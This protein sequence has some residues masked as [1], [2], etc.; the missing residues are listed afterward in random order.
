[1]QPEH[2]QRLLAELARV[3]DL[4]LLA[5]EP[6]HGS[7]DA[8][9]SRFRANFSWTHPYRRYGEA[10]GLVTRSFE[11]GEQIFYWGTTTR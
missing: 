3:R 7:P 2:L 4:D 9:A 6:Y 1:M 11:I 8:P 5:R 10:A